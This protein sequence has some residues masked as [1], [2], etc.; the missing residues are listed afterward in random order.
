MAK[1]AVQPSPEAQIRRTQ[2]G[3]IC[4]RMGRGQVEVML[5]T[6][7]DTG[8]WVI[9]KGWPMAGLTDWETAAREAWE[10]A[11]AEGTV[12][13]QPLGAFDYDKVL[14]PSLAVPC[15]VQV[16][17]LRVSALKSKFPEKNQRSRKW[18]SCKKAARKV[19]EPGLRAILLALTP[20]MLEQKT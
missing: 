2:S 17:A 6:S 5:I 19:V 20:E 9:P 18:F 13:P 4:W 3:A 14:R 11:G 16:F 12:T 7:R 10:E 8:R 15:Q 1:D